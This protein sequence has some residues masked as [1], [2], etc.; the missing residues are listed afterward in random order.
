MAIS[1][2]IMVIAKEYVFTTMVDVLQA[3]TRTLHPMLWSCHRHSHSH[4]TVIV[5]VA[6]FPIQF[7]S[8]SDSPPLI[9]AILLSWGQVPDTFETT[10]G[11]AP[12]LSEH[13]FMF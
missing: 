5:I 3:S 2:F 6:P 1:I 11:H 4:D 7:L 12:G 9:R 10:N 13:A 8:A